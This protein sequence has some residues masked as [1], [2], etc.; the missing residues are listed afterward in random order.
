MQWILNK[1]LPNVLWPEFCVLNNVTFEEMDKHLGLSAV[2]RSSF[3]LFAESIQNIG[4]N[5][6]YPFFYNGLLAYIFFFYTDKTYSLKEP[7]R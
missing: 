1:N 6:K 4:S 3:F 5:F 7:K 2:D